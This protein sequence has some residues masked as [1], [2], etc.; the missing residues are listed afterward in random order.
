[1][2]H[3]NGGGKGMRY[4][5][6]HKQ[7]TRERVLQEAAKAIRLEGPHQ[8]GVAGVMSRA[9]LTHGGFYAH[10]KSKDD[11]VA[12]AIGQMFVESGGRL[13]A[14]TEGR[15]PAEGLR[16]YI[17]FYLSRSHRDS[18]ESGCPLPFLA[19]DAPR[20]T[21]QARERFAAGVAG[22]RA[23]LA[24]RL[25]ELGVDH[26]EDEASS[27]LSELVGALSLARA[28]PDLAASDAILRRSR[29]ALRRRYSLDPKQPDLKS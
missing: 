1:M 9:G 4:G 7:K 8:V 21:G 12:E 22:L 14:E 20:L 24:A 23:G 13:A 19:A 26:A 10:F 18:R 16:S 29:A 3:I 27:M 15:T 11:F 2:Y 28:E 17:N 5:A 25:A 6:E